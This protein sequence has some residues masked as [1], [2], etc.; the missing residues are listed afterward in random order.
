MREKGL[1]PLSL[2]APDPKSGVSANS[3]TLANIFILFPS[4]NG[5]K[6]P[7]KTG[8]SIKIALFRYCIYRINRTVCQGL[9]NRRT[10]NA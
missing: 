4:F 6:P 5:R 2:A 10:I 8:F 9:Q 3:T 7:Q 1:E